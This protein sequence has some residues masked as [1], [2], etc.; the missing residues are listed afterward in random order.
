VDLQLNPSE[1]AFRTELLDWLSDHLVGEFKAFD[2]QGGPCDDYGWDLRVAWDRELSRGGWLGL[3]WPAE[4]SG[5]PATLK[6]EIVFHVELAKARTPYQATVNSIDLLGPALLLFGTE[7]QKQRFIP[8]IVHVEEFWC[9]GFSEPN[10]GSDLAGLMTRAELDGDR[11]I[12]N[13]QKIWTSTAAPANWIYVLC[14]TQPLDERAKHRG[15]TML[16]V[17]IDQPG[18]E[19]R[20]IRTMMN[21]DDL[22]EVF[23]DNAVTTADL[24][25]GPVH[26]GW[27]TAQGALGVERGTT[28]LPY[29]IRFEHELSDLIARVRPTGVLDNPVHRDA[30]ARAWAELGVLRMN[31]E[32][33]L[34]ALLQGRDPGPVAAIGKSV[35][36]HWHQRIGN[37]KMQLIGMDS[38][39]TGPDYGLDRVQRSFLVSRSETIYG[40]SDQIQHNIIGERV[41][42]LPR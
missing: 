33:L 24:V 21:A 29:Q 34:S 13:G 5:R 3:G 27:K 42:G 30:V 11:W 22:C 39:L 12:I 28:L 18:V 25:M 9:Q 20:T 26:D 37:L 14:R 32:R 4:Y 6:E 36:S 15:L 16:L 17:P 31:N 35:A 8:P 10:A 19:V 40:G 38:M 7:A 2:G 41:L 23:F 1:Q